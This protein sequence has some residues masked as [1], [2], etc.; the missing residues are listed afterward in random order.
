MC[1]RLDAQL[2]LPEATEKLGQESARDPR[3]DGG[4]GEYYRGVRPLHLRGRD[5]LSECACQTPLA[6]P[7][8]T[9]AD[10]SE[11]P[12]APAELL[13]AGEQGVGLLTSRL[14]AENLTRSRPCRLLRA[15]RTTPYPMNWASCCTTAPPNGTKRSRW[16]GCS[17][18]K[19]QRTCPRPR[20]RPRTRPPSA[21]PSPSST[22][23]SRNAEA[24][25][26]PLRRRPSRS[27]MR[28]CRSNREIWTL[29]N[30]QLQS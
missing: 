27:S 11:P 29:S 7:S 14:G 26:P 8:N 25:F 5:A 9:Y 1:G 19:Y 6:T 13:P 4:G 18:R 17:S 30:V 20:A 16:F 2:R 3:A 15:P 23:S 21:S 24:T 22:R 10:S 12:G 28:P